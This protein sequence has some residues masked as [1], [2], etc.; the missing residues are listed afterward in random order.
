MIASNVPTSIF[1]LLGFLLVVQ[2]GTWLNTVVFVP[3][4]VFCLA[5][6]YGLTASPAKV[7]E[8]VRVFYS[9]LP[10]FRGPTLK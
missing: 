1:C 4:I 8:A 10:E 7:H 2:S 6:L 3:L 5:E 9:D